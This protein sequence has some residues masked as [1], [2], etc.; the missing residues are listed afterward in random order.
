MA[1]PNQS[2]ET[3]LAV[4]EHIVEGLRNSVDE[5]RKHMVTVEH[6]DTKLE[7]LATKSELSTLAG[8]VAELERS[9][10]GKLWGKLTTFAAGGVTVYAA[11]EA[12]G[13]LFGKGN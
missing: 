5:V 1:P 6:L 9:T 13:K 12:L 3:T 7:A 10:L 8:R 2:P 4:L 11:V